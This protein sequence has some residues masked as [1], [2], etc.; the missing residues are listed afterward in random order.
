[1]A[2]HAAHIQCC[3]HLDGADIGGGVDTVV[4][5]FEIG[6]QFGERVHDFRH[7]RPDLHRRLLQ[8]L[9]KVYN[10]A[11]SILKVLDAL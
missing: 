11:S 9:H 7:G 5:G 2:Q 4:H 1:M 6:A 10:N 8:L 3:S